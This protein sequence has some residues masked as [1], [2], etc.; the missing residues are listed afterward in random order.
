M[1]SCFY[2]FFRFISTFYEHAFI[3]P[4]HLWGGLIIVSYLLTRKPISRDTDWRAQGH[5][6]RKVKAA[7]RSQ[8]SDSIVDAV[9]LYTTQQDLHSSRISIA[10]K[11]MSGSVPT[12][13]RRGPRRTF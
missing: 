8:F 3:Y 10:K 2:V 7:S 13:S 4:L 6:T 5:T 12:L 1:S 11:P 9:L